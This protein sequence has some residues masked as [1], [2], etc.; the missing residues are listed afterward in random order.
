[1]S[2]R[3]ICVSR[4]IDHG[5]AILLIGETAIDKRTVHIAFDWR[6]F[7]EFWLD[8]CR[9]GMPQP[10]YYDDETKTLRFE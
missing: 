5:S 3:A 7:H 2:E 9:A 8:W 4:V 1:V 10:I 6:P